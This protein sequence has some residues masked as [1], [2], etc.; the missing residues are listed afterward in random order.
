MSDI[1]AA[2]AKR[3]ML[4]NCC[5]CPYKEMFCIRRVIRTPRYRRNDI[6]LLLPE[7]L[8]RGANLQIEIRLR[9]IICVA[10]LSLYLSVLGFKKGTTISAPRLA[11]GLI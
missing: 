2:N 3:L 11:T 6:I 4:K 7:R 5:I 8:F 10:G 1:L 9:A